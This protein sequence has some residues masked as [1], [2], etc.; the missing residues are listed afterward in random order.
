MLYRKK[1]NERMQRLFEYCGEDASFFERVE[2]GLQ[3]EQQHPSPWSRR[4]WRCT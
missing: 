4:I 3:H 1:V 2:L